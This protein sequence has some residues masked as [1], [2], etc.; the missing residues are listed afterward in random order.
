MILHVGLQWLIKNKKRKGIRRKSVLREQWGW[1]W[2]KAM[3]CDAHGCCEY[4]LL[5]LVNREVALAY[6]RME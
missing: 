2:L 3:M 4:I 1:M 5:I 6:G